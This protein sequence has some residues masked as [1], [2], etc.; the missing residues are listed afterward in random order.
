MDF[1]MAYTDMFGAKLVK[2]LRYQNC[3]FFHFVFFCFRKLIVCD[4]NVNK[5]LFKFAFVKTMAN[6]AD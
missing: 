6:F 1:N 5:F 3:I 4:R 2:K